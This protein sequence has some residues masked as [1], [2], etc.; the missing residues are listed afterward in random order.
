MNQNGFAN[1]VLILVI[2]V[3]VIGGGYYFFN[4]KVGAPIESNNNLIKSENPQRQ[5]I[6]EQKINASQP[7]TE[8]RQKVLDE[9]L[10][11]NFGGKSPLDAVQ[12]T[13]AALEQNNIEEAIKYF[14]LT[15]R[16]IPLSLSNDNK[17]REDHIRCFKEVSKGKLTYGEGNEIYG[18]SARFT[19]TDSSGAPLG[20]ID[21][22]KY[23][24]NNLWKIVNCVG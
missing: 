15:S 18:Q 4:K 2:M 23:Q 11:D 8:Q 12:K 1:I 10:K 13:I 7:V 16:G 17:S 24:H 19:L 21:F 3:A 22:L 5:P 14:V 20:V 9:Y 6:S